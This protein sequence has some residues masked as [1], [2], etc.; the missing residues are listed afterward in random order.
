MTRGEETEKTL[1]IVITEIVLY[2][3]FAFPPDK[4]GRGE[5][6]CYQI[7]LLIDQESPDCLRQ[8]ENIVLTITELL[9]SQI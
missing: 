6:N 8:A 4:S 3:L 5:G 7:V 2:D 1:C 9:C